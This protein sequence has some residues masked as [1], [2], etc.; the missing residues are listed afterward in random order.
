MKICY[1]LLRGCSCFGVGRGGFGRGSRPLLKKAGD[2]DGFSD[3][4]DPKTR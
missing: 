1:F 3:G 4:H 2:R